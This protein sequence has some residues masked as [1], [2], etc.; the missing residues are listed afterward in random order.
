MHTTSHFVGLKIKSSSLADIFI[1][2][3]NTLGNSKNSFLFQNIL[4]AH[5]TLFYF[6]DSISED[7][8]WKIAQIIKNLDISEIKPWIRWFEYFWDLSNPKL[9]YLQTQENITLEQF[10]YIFRKEFPQYLN[11]TDNAYPT[12]APHIF[13]NLKNIKPS[14]EYISTSSLANELDVKSTELFEKLKNI[15]I[16]ESIE[17][18]QVNSQFQPEIQI[19]LPLVL[20]K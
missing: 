18:F 20:E 8:K 16:F 17:L 13:D 10:H 1:K 6:P 19:I 2:I 12:Y 11:I 3:Q 9:C 15:E 7:E 5:I 4:S 14:M